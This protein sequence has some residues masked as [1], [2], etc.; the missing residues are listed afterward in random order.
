MKTLKFQVEDK[1]MESLDKLAD[2]LGMKLNA[3]VQM[4]L[5]IH[6]KEKEGE[7]NG[8]AK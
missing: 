3:Y 2:D 4:V 7:I 6:V 1:I 5:G 8:G